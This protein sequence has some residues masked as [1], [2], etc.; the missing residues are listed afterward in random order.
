MSN[1]LNDASKALLR[2]LARDPFNGASA[3]ALQTAGHQPVTIRRLYKAGL[4]TKFTRKI[5]NPPGLQVT[6]YRISTMGL[7]RVEGGPQY[8]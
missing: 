1:D 4:I 5:S 3:E 2:M 6:A 8:G 7:G